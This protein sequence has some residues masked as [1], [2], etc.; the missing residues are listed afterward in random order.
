M[1]PKQTVQKAVRGVPLL[2]FQGEA[3]TAMVDDAGT[4]IRDQLID[5]SKLAG[6]RLEADL[7]PANIPN[8]APHVVYSRGSVAA[9]RS[10][11]GF[12]YRAK[13]EWVSSEP[14]SPPHRTDQ[15]VNAPECDHI[16]RAKHRTARHHKPPQA[17]VVAGALNEIMIERCTAP[18]AVMK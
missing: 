18:I 3:P 14:E 16:Q 9:Y 17:S 4:V 5:P 15:R 12:R 1:L 13:V 6:R 2:K 8:C 7:D 10:A 11:T